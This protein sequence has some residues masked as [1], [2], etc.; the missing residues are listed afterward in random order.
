[1]SGEHRPSGGG[2]GD[3][4]TGAR[5]VFV[6]DLPAA[7]LVRPATVRLLVD[8]GLSAIVSVRP[9][10]VDETFEVRRTLAVAGV[11]VTLWP[12]LADAAGRW[13]NVR[14]VAEMRGF[15]ARLIERAAR[16]PG[17]VP[18]RV[19]LD[20]EPPIDEVRAVLDSRSFL[21]LGRLIRIL[22]APG[23][24]RDLDA[25]VR[26][27]G[28][29]G[30]EVSAALV[31]F[32]LADGPLGAVSRLLGVPAAR[33]TFDPAWIMTYT[34]LFAGYSRGYVDRAQ[35]KEILAQ[36]ARR[37]RRIFGQGAAL[38]LGCVGRGA[39]G[40]EAVYR[41]VDELSEDVAIAI[42]EGIDRLALFDLGGVL[43][44]EAPERWLRAFVAR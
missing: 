18:L 30:G 23:G 32:V 44:R 20:L 38:A 33:G 4:R 42:R 11:P 19:L 26:S 8:H 35:A 36:A 40:D 12:M 16:E 34:T 31:P 9:W 7:E 37:A 29:A 41:E 14:T 24:A 5:A 6:E 22:A 3:A 28:L 43:A 27:V 15:V 39:L 1:M 13:V 21:A 17:A 10:N 25:L 2:D